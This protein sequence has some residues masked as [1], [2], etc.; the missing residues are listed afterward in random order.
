MHERQQFM[1]YWLLICF[2]SL[3]F[4]ALAQSN[5][6]DADREYPPHYATDQVIVLVVYPRVNLRTAPSTS[7]MV[8]DIARL[9]ER[10]PIIGTDE[11]EQWFLVQ[12]GSGVVWIHDGSVLTANAEELERIGEN[13]SPEFINSVNAQVAFAQV[14]V[15]VR[16]ALN[17]RGGASTNAAIIGRVPADGRVFVQGRDAYGTWILVNYSGAVGWVSSAYLA[18]PPDYRLDLVPIVR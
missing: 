15:G 5:D 2:L 18:F 16:G 13:P 10:F 4:P 12:S 6:N 8:V 1:K 14:T 3:A 9:G 17:I 11:T 7:S